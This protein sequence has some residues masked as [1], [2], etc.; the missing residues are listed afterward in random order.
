MRLAWSSSNGQ[1][2][3]AFKPAARSST[4]KR[5]NSL[6]DFFAPT[7]RLQRLRGG[8]TYY[9]PA[10]SDVSEIVLVGALQDLLAAGWAWSD[11]LKVSDGRIVWVNDE[12]FLANPQTVWRT[13][14]TLMAATQD[15]ITVN[16]NAENWIGPYEQCWLTV[17]VSYQQTVACKETGIVG[18]YTTGG[19]DAA[20]AKLSD[21][22]L[23][24]TIPD[25][26]LQS[27]SLAATSNAVGTTLSLS[28]QEL[29][30]ILQNHKRLGRFSLQRFHIHAEQCKSLLQAC[31]NNTTLSLEMC[32]FRDNAVALADCLRTNQAAPARLSLRWTKF[33]DTAW[34]A[35]CGALA[36]NTSLQS[37]HLIH[38][39]RG[40]AQAAAFTDCLVEN[41]GL[42]E[43]RWRSGSLTHDAVFRQLC[44]ALANHKTLEILEAFSN[45]I[46]WRPLSLPREMSR[47]QVLIET[48]LQENTL[49]QEIRLGFGHSTD[50]NRYY[51]RIIRGL[52]MR[53]RYSSKRLPALAAEQSTTTQL[54]VLGR[55]LEAIHHDPDQVFL[56]LSGV[57][58]IVL[59]N[60]SSCSTMVE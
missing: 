14:R 25:D 50:S 2:P 38:C 12:T 36:V 58:G 45:P 23:L 26:D 54:A 15:S 46:P 33:E 51:L 7:D 29:Q 3:A 20:S 16:D 32:S 55:A 42:V 24:L 13:I 9:Q 37:L 53:N 35:F 27:I 41:Q 48:L 52:L 30:S 28:A 57:W 49:L 40:L 8:E 6:A 1:A 5:R 34:Q 60:I 10:S 43:L 21:L 44:R 11:L 56:L 39:C 22:V 19:M 59:P 47:C 18:I 17:S 4:P 31:G